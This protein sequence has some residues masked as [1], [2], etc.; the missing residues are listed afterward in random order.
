MSTIRTGMKKHAM[1]PAIRSAKAILFQVPT[2]K[3]ERIAMKR[4]GLMIV[5]ALIL[6]VATAAVLIVNITCDSGWFEAGDELKTRCYMCIYGVGPEF[7]DGPLWSYGILLR[8]YRV[9]NNAPFQNEPTACRS[10]VAIPIP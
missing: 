8:D 3:I 10:G 7:S 5:L 6:L 1:L 2:H 4:H 9:H